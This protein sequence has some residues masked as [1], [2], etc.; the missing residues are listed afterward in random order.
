[1]PFSLEGWLLEQQ[2]SVSW[3]NP[4]TVNWTLEFTVNWVKQ[5]TSVKLSDPREWEDRTQ[6]KEGFEVAQAIAKMISVAKWLPIP[7]GQY[8]EWKVEIK[9]SS[10]VILQLLKAALKVEN[11]VSTE[12]DEETENEKL[13]AQLKDAKKRLTNFENWRPELNEA[14]PYPNQ[15][16]TI[17]GDILEKLENPERGID[18]LWTY[19]FG[20]KKVEWINA[21]LDLWEKN[22]RSNKIFNLWEEHFEYE[23]GTKARQSDKIKNLRSRLTE[24]TIQDY[25]GDSITTLLWDAAYSKNFTRFLATCFAAG[26]KLRP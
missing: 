1:M 8:I 25:D 7:D 18:W 17:Y 13:R 16:V 19:F 12:D 2:V 5:D 22:I 26:I 6:L 10:L 14:P 3:T 20:L 24:K 15:Y 11:L 23:R 9:I 21:F 4:S